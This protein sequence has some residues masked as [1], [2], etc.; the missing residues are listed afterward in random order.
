MHGCA[1]HHDDGQLGVGLCS[2]GTIHKN[3]AP[4]E[5]HRIVSCMVNCC[6]LV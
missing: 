6:V 2:G 3:I 5:R 1:T 4:L